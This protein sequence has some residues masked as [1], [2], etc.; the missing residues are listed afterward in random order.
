MCRHRRLLGSLAVVTLLLAACSGDDDE[1]AI[2]PIDPP[3]EDVDAD[4]A[5][6]DPDDAEGPS[7][8]EADG[9]ADEGVDEGVDED[10]DAED[11]E[12][13][14]PDE[15]DPDYAERVINELQERINALTIQMR[16]EVPAGELLPA[17]FRDAFASIY[18]PDVL[19][20]NLAGIQTDVDTGFEAFPDEL[21]PWIYE[22]DSILEQDPQS[23]LAVTGVA[24]ASAVTP[25]GSQL[26]FDDWIIVLQRAGDVDPEVNETGWLLYESVALADPGPAVWEDACA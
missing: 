14:V 9:S 13:A 23:C 24:D 18:A 22:A 1:R 4:E 2:D 20:R 21:G 19:A 12:W 26:I 10:P 7:D 17:E 16:D 5:G 3:S 25:D 6:D 11:D 8:A 15:I